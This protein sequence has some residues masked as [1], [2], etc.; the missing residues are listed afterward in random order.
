MRL[1]NLPNITMLVS[2]EVRVW[3]QAVWLHSMFLTTLLSEIIL[4]RYH[5]DFMI[6]IFS[7]SK[8]KKKQQNNN[9]SPTQLSQYF[10]KGPLCLVCACVSSLQPTEV[11]KYQFFTVLMNSHS[12]TGETSVCASL[13][14][15]AHS[16]FLHCVLFPFKDLL[17]S[18]VNL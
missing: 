5:F 10:D 12:S 11:K 13:F 16:F 14:L 1:N 17:K 3:I 9:S 7:L 6:T 2:S 15:I 8:S 18:H 4:L